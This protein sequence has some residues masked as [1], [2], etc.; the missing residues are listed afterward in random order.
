MYCEVSADRDSQIYPALPFHLSRSGILCSHIHSSRFSQPFMRTAMHLPRHVT[1]D[2]LF[3]FRRNSWKYP[4]IIPV[5]SRIIMNLMVRSV[6]YFSCWILKTSGDGYTTAVLEYLLNCCIS[7]LRKTTKQTTTKI[8][9]KKKIQ[10]NLS[11]LQFLSDTIF[12]FHLFIPW[13]C[14]CF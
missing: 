6:I 10:F 4:W 3:C 7:L 9:K 8:K 11:E 12:L 13:R 5:Q 1:D 14:S 2:R